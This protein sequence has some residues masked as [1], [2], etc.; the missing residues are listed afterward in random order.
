MRT[1]GNSKRQAWERRSRGAPRL[2]LALL[3]SGGALAFFWSM[4]RTEPTLRVEPPLVHEGAPV[5]LVLN[6]G[7]PQPPPEATAGS[8]P[9]D[10]TKNEMSPADTMALWSRGSQCHKDLV[11]A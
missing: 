8:L 7:G 5:D 3:V 6:V 1:A 10:L 4:T 9:V 2:C 11:V